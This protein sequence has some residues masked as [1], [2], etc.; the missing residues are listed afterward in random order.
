MKGMSG[1]LLE[2]PSAPGAA[3][4]AAVI[5]QDDVRAG[6]EPRVCRPV[7]VSSTADDGRPGC[8]TMQVRIVRLDLRRHQHLNRTAHASRSTGGSD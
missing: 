8:S 3:N 6:G 1:P 2:R 4:P 5:R 7:A